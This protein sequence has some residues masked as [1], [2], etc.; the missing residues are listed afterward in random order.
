MLANVPRPGRDFDALWRY[1]MEGPAGAKPDPNRVAWVEMRNLATKNPKTGAK[2]MKAT[3]DLSVRVQR[4]VYHLIVSHH[5]NEAPTKEQMLEVADTTLRDMGLEQ[6]QAIII[7]HADTPNRH[8]HVMINRV[9]PGTGVAWSTSHDYPRLEHS[10]RRQSEAHGFILVPGRH[11][12]PKTFKDRTKNAGRG[13]LQLLKKKGRADIPQWAIAKTKALG[14]HLK[15][16]FDT[17]TSWSELEQLLQATGVELFAKGQGLVVTDRARSGYAKLS[18]LGASIRL[19]DLEARFGEC[20]SEHR[21]KNPRPRQDRETRPL[22]SELDVL[23][24]LYRA[25][26]ARRADVEA[27]FDERERKLAE[28]PVVAQIEHE[29]RE[30]LRAMTKKPVRTKRP[31]AGPRTDREPEPHK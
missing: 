6:H 26:L 8:F 20:W 11:T 10:M 16:S 23:I 3:A 4:P 28:A 12:E 27:A 17:A 7:A 14:Q 5:P 2:V 21:T 24:S 22:V 1:L 9:H 15:S 19:K 25:G 13:E 18:A 31:R 30:A 29:M